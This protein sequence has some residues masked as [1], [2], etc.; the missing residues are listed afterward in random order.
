MGRKC[1]L[2]WCTYGCFIY[3]RMDLHAFACV[4]EVEQ[5]VQAIYY[6][7]R[8]DWERMHLRW[9]QDMEEIRRT[10]RGTPYSEPVLRSIESIRK[11]SFR[12]F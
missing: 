8:R 4:C 6:H 3:K 2:I 10:G 12:K 11:E 7:A 1:R 9:K 5:C